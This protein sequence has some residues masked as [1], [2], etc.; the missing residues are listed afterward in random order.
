[1]TQARHSLWQEGEQPAYPALDDN[2]HFDVVV[3]GAGIA[4]LTTALLLKRQG[5]RVSVL[6]SGGVASGATGLNTGKVSAL[7]STMYSAINSHRGREAA[8]TYAAASMAAVGKLVDLANGE[9]IECGLRH[10][11]AYTYA[12][13]DVELGAVVR[14]VEAAQRA[15]L[16]VEFREDTDLPFPVKGSVALADQLEFDPVRYTGGLA[17]AVH[18]DGCAVYE[19]TRAVGLDEGAPCGIQTT[20]GLVTADQVVV[21]T[22]YPIFDR[23]L[24]FARLEPK[25]SYCIAARTRGELPSG[26]SINPGNPTRSLRSCGDL[27]VVCGEGHAT[28][29][30][31]ISETRYEQLEDFTR[32]HWDVEEFTH[33]W[34]AQDPTSYDHF[35]MV[36][37]YTPVSA[38]VYAATAFMKWGLTGG[39]FAGMLLADLIGGRD[40]P[41]REAFSPTRLSASSSASLARINFNAGM[42]FV[43]DRIAPGQ[44]TEVEKVARGQARVVRQ[45]SEPNGVY[46]D[47]DGLLHVVSLR[48]THLGC[49]LRFNGAEL[50]WDC[51]CH[52]SRFDVDGEVLEGPAVHPLRKPHEDRP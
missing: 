16:P 25:R 1:M 45:H 11:N 42:D 32:K 37:S 27:L 3:I 19:N 47:H 50:S 44:A 14:E 52:G 24:Y 13:D 36:G 5:C 20:R 51:P 33:R 2:R 35:P 40:T 6:E 49:L 12:T 8:E 22:H 15:G 38:R 41:W 9:S 18:G 17:A 28:G 43:A 7:Q 39:T 29:A 46:R 31:G 30:R 26:L 34:S 4:G 48:C 10:R 21:A 23:G